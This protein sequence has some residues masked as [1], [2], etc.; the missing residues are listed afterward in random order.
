MTCQFPKKSA[1]STLLSA[2]FAATILLPASAAA[3]TPDAPP[4]PPLTDAHI[5]GFAGVMVELS[6]WSRANSG[7][8]AAESEKW[9][10]ER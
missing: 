1:A 2:L 9:T 5:N 10:G 6:A 3:Q 8:W 4:P 7:R